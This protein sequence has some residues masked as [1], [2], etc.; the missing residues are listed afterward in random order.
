MRRIEQQSDGKFYT[1]VHGDPDRYV[2]ISGASHFPFASQRE[3]TCQPEAANWEVSGVLQL[4]TYSGC[5][6]CTAKVLPLTDDPEFGQCIKCQMMQCM[7]D[8][9]KEL[10]TQ[11]LIKLPT[12]QITLRAFGKTILDIAQRPA[13][14]GDISQISFLKAAPFNELQKWNHSNC[15]KKNLDIATNNNKLLLI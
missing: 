8:V 7:A 12:G 14:A 4:D 1:E 5:M 6:K 10:S 11:L 15:Y 3:K 13:G 2:E 9:N